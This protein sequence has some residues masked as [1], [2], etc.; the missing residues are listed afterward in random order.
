MALTDPRHNYKPF[1]YGQA[2]KFSTDQ[3]DSFWVAKECALTEDLL[4]WK[5]K[6]DDKERAVVAGV[7]KGFTQA[8]LVIGDY[9]SNVVRWFPKPEIAC[10]ARTFSFFEVV[11]TEAY[12][13]LSDTLGLDDFEAFLQDP[14]AQAKYGNLISA[15]DES[16]EDIARSLAVFSAFAEGVSLF[17]SFAVLM[18]FPALNK[19][20]GL[21]T[22]VEYSSRD[23]CIHAEAGIWLF[24]TYL[25][26]N[27]HLRTDKL[28][29]DIYEAARTCVG[30]EEGFIDSI[31][32]QGDLLGLKAIDLK[33][34]IRARANQKL[35]QLGYKPILDF[36]SKS[37][38]AISGWFEVFTGGARNH[39]FFLTRETNYSRGDAFDPNELD[40]K[41]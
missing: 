15:R 28:E 17:S 24:N 26:E 36:D 22:I 39:D 29:S 31:F 2:H 40:F 41:F 5:V 34:Y 7:L 38:E 18:R 19:L 10:M 21:G 27:S 14:A 12:S 37:A 13:Y 3:Q 11:H 25:E 1:E 6:L 16:D 35:I 30:L 4:D 33:N 9:W 8:E 20:K 32:D 23:E